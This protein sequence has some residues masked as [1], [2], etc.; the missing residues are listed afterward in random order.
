MIHEETGAFGNGTGDSELATFGR[1]GALDE[2]RVDPMGPDPVY[3]PAL[4]SSN[5]YEIGHGCDG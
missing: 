1:I 3:D 5:I 4:F 2:M